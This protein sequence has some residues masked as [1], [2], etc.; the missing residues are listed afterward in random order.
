MNNKLTIAQR[1][2][3]IAGGAYG[4]LA[5]Y[6]MFICQT[7]LQGAR[8]Q[9]MT[10]VWMYNIGLIPLAGILCVWMFAG[11]KVFTAGVHRA[12]IASTGLFV[13]F[14]LFTYGEQTGVINYTLY[15]AIPNL[16]NQQV[17]LYAFMV[18]RLM[19]MIVATFFVTN[20]CKAYDLLPQKKEEEEAQQEKSAEA[21]V[22]LFEEEKAAEEEKER[23]DDEAVKE[24]DEETAARE[25]AEETAAEEKAAEKKAVKPAAKKTPAK[26]PEAKKAPARKP[27][28]K[29]A[30]EEK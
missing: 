3:W 28:A 7:I 4:A 25:A 24:L 10:T 17:W 29:K 15:Y 6:Q 14:E 20:N 27:A 23:I 18:L 12:F 21:L 11:K 26:K 1:M 8:L 22:E 19:L 9:E 2:R 13:A 16:A 5:L 30:E